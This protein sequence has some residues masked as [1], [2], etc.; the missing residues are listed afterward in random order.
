MTDYMIMNT[1]D[2]GNIGTNVLSVK[3]LNAHAWV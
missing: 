2:D 1:D 3:K